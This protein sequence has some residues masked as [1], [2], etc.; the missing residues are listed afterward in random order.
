M[1]CSI[2]GCGKVHAARGWCQ[3]HYARWKRNGT[4]DRVMP[5]LLDRLLAK[6]D[7]DGP[8]SLLRRAPG[9]C[10]LWTGYINDTGYGVVWVSPGLAMR[11]AHRVAYM[12]LVGPIPDG[13][14]LDHL[15]RVRHCVNPAHLEPV[16]PRENK[17]R[18]ISPAAINAAKTHCI[19]G[20]EFT[21]ENTYVWAPRA[22]RQCRACKAERRAAA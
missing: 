20:H 18:G 2:D 14:V 16:V 21:P 7:Q 6:V 22:M 1:T 13:L 11:N 4:T 10:W 17:L 12:L 9:R 3:M 15:C 8:W 5:S 19:N